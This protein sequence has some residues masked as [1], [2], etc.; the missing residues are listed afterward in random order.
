MKTPGVYVAEELMPYLRARIAEILYREGLRQ[1]RIAAYLGITQAMVSK[2]L[3]GNYRRPPGDV[4]GFLDSIAEEIANLIL[5]GAPK[6][7][8]IAFTSRRLFELFSSG[9]LCKHY[10]RYAG[11]SEETCS[12]LFVSSNS[13]AVEEMKLALRELLSLPGFSKLVPEVRSNLAY[14]PPGAKSPSDVIAIPGRITLVKG[15]PYALPPEFGASR[16]TASLI[17]AVADRNP[18]IRSVMNVKLNEKIAKAVRRLGFKHVETKTGGLS[19]EDAVKEIAN[20]FEKSS[21]DFILDWGGEG[22]EPLVYVF[23]KNPL[24]VVKKVKALLEVV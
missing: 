4:A 23:G 5:T 8:I 16:F 13:T 1:S 17:L 14:A 2:Y 18:E 24:D 6:D 19:Y 21:P 20:I 3:G 11:I 10:A 12:S 22:V 9:R 7:E 15:R